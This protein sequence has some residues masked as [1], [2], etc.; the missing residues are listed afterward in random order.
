[1]TEFPLAPRQ[2]R[3][4][5]E[6]ILR[7]PNVIE[8]TIIAAAF[9]STQSPYLL[10]PG[11]EVEA[12]K[13][14]HLF[15]DPGG[16]FVSYL[17]L[18]RS[19]GDS[20]NKARF[21]EKNYLDERAMAEIVNVTAQL[22]AIVSDMDI[23]VL[24]GGDTVDYLCCVARGHIQFVC[25]REG[26]ETY[27][28][29]TADRIIIHPGSVMFRMDPRY[30]VAGEIVR[31][32][33]TYAMSVSPLSAGILERL[34]PD[35]FSSFGAPREKSAG[36]S[37]DGAQ[38]LKKPRDFS[39]NIK[40]GGEVFEI[41]AFK[42]KKQV[43]LPWERL[44]RI[45]DKLGADTVYRGLRGQINV[46]GYSLLAGEKLELIFSLVPTL[47]ID[48]ALKRT[49][50]RRKNFNSGADLDVLLGH[51]GGLACPAIWKPGRKDMGFIGLFTDGEGNYWFRCS[52]GFHT[53]LNES[54]A[55]LET[56]IDELGESVD[57]E[58]KNMVNQVY[59][60]LSEYL[61]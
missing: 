4:I 14:H 48:G 17:K 33:R 52:R 57:I 32:T 35:L 30:I 59:R 51:L 40:I 27:R 2:S 21:C 60:R 23:P 53:S 8:E 41:S 10:P 22:A 16:D 56:L 37:R 12:R 50:P 9:L 11:E 39:N 5:V 47:D 31:T 34:S 13:A 20:T 44:S 1:M 19:Y 25:V 58:K 49:W 29:L 24:A 6:A 3:I 43:L 61:A 38:K 36:T 15:R 55:S 45:R 26:R 46:E 18:Y 42:G 7:Y 54:L 28:S